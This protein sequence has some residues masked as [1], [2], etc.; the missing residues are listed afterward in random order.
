[1]L[2]VNGRVTLSRRRY[3]AKDVGSFTPLDDWIDQAHARISHGV[4][5]M[6]CRLNQGARCNA[7]AAEN[8]ARTAPL[9]L[10]RQTLRERVL[11]EGKAVAAAAKHGRRVLT[12]DAS[13]CFIPDDKGR[14]TSA[15][16]VSLGMDGVMVPMV[17]QAEKDKRRAQSKAKRRLRGRRCRPRPRARPGADESFQETKIV[18]DDDEPCQHRLVVLTRGHGDEA[19]PWMRRTAGRIGLDKAPAKVAVVD[20]AEWMRN[21]IKGQSMPLDAL[22]LDCYHRAENVPKAR[23]AVYG[24]RTPRTSRRRATPGRRRC[25]TWPGTPASWSSKRRSGTGRSAGGGQSGRRRGR[26]WTTS[27]TGRRGSGSRSSRSRA[28]RSVADRRSRCARR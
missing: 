19:G 10:R 6:A 9:R 12:W 22:G 1:V 5:A 25:C 15:T 7:K 11:A 27:A 26:C 16:R 8:R 4:R 18:T 14:P 23:R 13:A 17:T 28:G 21:H 2:T 3:F 24:R 20:G